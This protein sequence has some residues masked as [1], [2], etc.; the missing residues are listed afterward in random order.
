[1][2][3]TPLNYLKCHIRGP[4]VPPSVLKSSLIP[5]M[6]IANVVKLWPCKLCTQILMSLQATAHNPHPERWERRKSPGE[7]PDVAHKK[8]EGSHEALQDGSKKTIGTFSCLPR[9]RG[10]GGL[11]CSDPLCWETALIKAGM[12][13]PMPAGVWHAAHAGGGWVSNN[14]SGPQEVMQVNLKGPAFSMKSKLM[15]YSQS[16][17]SECCKSDLYNAMHSSTP[18][19]ALLVIHS[20][21]LLMLLVSL[22]CSWL[23]FKC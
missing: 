11:L 17:Q 23:L 12:W 7:A 1:M 9:H 4:W 5:I 10:A 14:T 21:H 22:C 6:A 15:D 2:P 3:P 16:H 20:A 18:P 19:A 8:V 13:S